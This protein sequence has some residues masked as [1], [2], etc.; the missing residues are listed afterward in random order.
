M[1]VFRLFFVFVCFR[2]VPDSGSGR[3][4]AFF[5]NPALAK[6]PPEPDTFAGFGQIRRS[7]AI[8]IIFCSKIHGVSHDSKFF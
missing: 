3:N 4:P 2:A 7:K 5:P 1:G 8:S 6:F